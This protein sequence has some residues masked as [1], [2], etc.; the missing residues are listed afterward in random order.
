MAIDL[1]VKVINGEQV[2]KEV[3]VPYVL[4][5]PEEADK[6]LAIYDSLK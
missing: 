5:M 4:V 2:E 1:A 6:Y 3:M